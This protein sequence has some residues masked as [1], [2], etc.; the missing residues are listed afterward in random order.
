MTVDVFYKCLFPEHLRFIIYVCL[1]ICLFNLL[2]SVFQQIKVHSDGCWTDTKQMLTVGFKGFS[3]QFKGKLMYSIL[4][5]FCIS[6]LVSC[7]L[8]VGK[9]PQ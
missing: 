3:R 7:R 2:S 6:L 4:L 9:R 8:G 1:L 5:L